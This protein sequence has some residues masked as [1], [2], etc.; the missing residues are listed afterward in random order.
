MG[1]FKPDVN[2]QTEYDK[3]LKDAEAKYGLP[4]NALKLVMQI[5][6][7]GRPNPTATSPAGAQGLM[8]IMPANQK[9]LGV[10]DPFDPAQS[11]DAAGRLMSE[12][13]QRYDGNLGA[14]LADYNG[15]PK[16][17]KKYLAGS[18]M[19]PETAQYVGFA[20]EYLNGKQ[21]SQYGESVIGAADIAVDARAPSD[22]FQSD[23][24]D[25]SGFITGLDA[26]TQASIEEESK[27][28]EL[29]MWEATKQGFGSTLT[30]ALYHISQGYDDPDF[31]M[32]EQ[33]YKQ[34]QEA[35]PQ[36]LTGDQEAMVRNS[37][38]QSDLQYNIDR[39]QQ[40]NDFSRRM[41]YQEGTSNIAAYAGLMAGG[42][43]DP[44]TLPMG[45][46]GMAGRVVKGG[47]VFAS[48]GR[49][50]IEGAAGAG[51][52]SPLI[53]LA[54]KGRVDA[55]DVMTNVAAGAI[56]GAGLGAAGK[57]LGW[58]GK[59]AFHA[60]M[61]SRM[62]S[63]LAGE[64]DHFTAAQSDGASV[65][66]SRNGDNLTG[67]AGE[68]VGV[69][70]SAVMRAAES[71]DE[72]V[73]PAVQ[74]VQDRRRKYMG[75]EW[76]KKLT[77][78]SDS[79]NVRLAN[80]ESKIARFVGAQ[81]AGDAMGLGKQ[82]ARNVAVGK[83][84]IKDTLQFEHIPDL[85]AQ[86]E[87]TLSPQELIDY[88]A[89][90]AN[91][92]Q[93]R[94]SKEVQLERFKHRQFRA[95]NNGSS[96]GYTSGAPDAVQLAA[97]NLDALAKTSKEMRIANEVDGWKTLVEADHVG[98]MSQRADYLTLARE[99][100]EKLAAFKEMVTSHYLADADNMLNNLRANKEQYIKDTWARYDANMEAPGLEA[101]LNDPDAYFESYINKMAEK[102]N[103]EAIT[104]S[105]HWW[106]NA[107]RAPDERF[108]NSEASLMNLAKELSAEVFGE[109]R[110][111]DQKMV[112]DFQNLLTD[113]WS[114]TT[115]R[116][117]D[118]SMSRMVNG[119]QV[120]LLDMFQHDAFATAVNSI[121]DT[122]GRVAMAK[123]GWKSEQNILDTLQAMRHSGATDREVQAAKHVADTILNRVNGIGNNAAI[124]TV[125][126]LTHA[127][128]MGKLG[129]SVLADMPTAIGNLG[130]GGMFEALGDMARKVTDGS[131]FIRNGRLTDIGSDLDALY[132][133]LMGHDNELWIP[134]GLSADG[135]AMESGG[136][137]LKRSAAAARFTN[138]MSGSNALSK[139]IGTGVT[140]TAN[141]KLHTFFK[142]GKG[143]SEER[144]ADVGLHR[145]VIDRIKAQFD[146]H[147]VDGEWG[148]SKW[149]D[150]VAKDALIGAGNRFAQ[151]S[152]MSR[153]YAGDTPKWT[154][155]NI[156]GYLYAKFR[157]IGIQ[158]QE[159]VLV[160]NLTLADSN[161]V[162]TM[163]GGVAFAA[164][165]AYGRI[166]ADAATNA[167]PDKVLKERLAPISFANTVT[168]LTSSMGLASEGM[169]LLQMITGGGVNGS[170]TPLTGAV[171]NYTD[172]FSKTGQAA[173]GNGEWSSAAKAGTKILP[174]ANTYQILM[175]KKA[176]SE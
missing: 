145:D 78:W 131:L 73:S 25:S 172:L 80:S 51:M 50:A 160:R 117:L 35:I 151:Q 156:L 125:N 100:P 149:D 119:E 67:V 134:K 28:H 39:V 59:D 7:R 89:G 11:V 15:G 52:A 164:F 16:Q 22:Q 60:E 115:R 79:E 61:N 45:S 150:P 113:K 87:R 69:G 17:A 24:A 64:N 32:G 83:E 58:A 10:T 127:A 170:D 82:E 143:I 107:I 133:G 43:F 176:L 29:S 20:Q 57:A 19:H 97:A 114:D 2:Q 18:M 3:L 48:A 122:A 158:A 47:S 81:W 105:G 161:A 95:A 27:Y 147:A 130:I 141:R 84:L 8:Q 44:V 126:N 66:F 76:R 70:P 159:K 168:M 171:K 74:A 36:G 53:Q 111:V 37:R 6:N 56:F 14:A 38:S 124:Q 72:S 96:E 71:W 85:K 174:G 62:E 65:D 98:Y 101:F 1:Q 116:E 112:K 23:S 33:Q 123:M 102:L 109:G 9:K 128:M 12:A 40:E 169:N 154:S 55:G 46:L 118:M 26:E 68:Q 103:K 63:R 49:M 173:T 91:D 155:D 152:Q 148:L 132:K 136:S 167:D 86:F 99:T 138:T 120:H 163:V 77:G 42:L 110:V 135:F 34:V 139:I 5:E 21:P 106:E 90:G 140:R 157:S 144:L 54:D 121:N 31:T 153:S 4:E 88:A 41:G 75:N 142:T 92:A 93:A 166:Y 13:Y 104:R 165:V 162:A 146:K 94:F 108:S 137:M 129:T 175:L 30:H